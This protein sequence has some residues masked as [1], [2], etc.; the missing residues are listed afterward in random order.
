MKFDWI[1]ALLIA[2]LIGTVVAFSTGLFPY[3]Y[4]WIVASMLLVY[5]LS[6]NRTPRES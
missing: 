1:T 5:R 6:A 3:P 2:A 4:G